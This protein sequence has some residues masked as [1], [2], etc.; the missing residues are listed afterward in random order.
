MCVRV[1]VCLC[2][3][4]CVEYVCHTHSTYIG[5]AKTIYIRCIY[6]NFGRK[7]TKYTVIYGV[8]IRFWPTL[9]IQRMYVCVYVCVRMCVLHTLTAIPVDF[10]FT[11]ACEL[12]S[13]T[14]TAT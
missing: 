14:D 13:G 1:C 3:L 10:K 12:H 7:I 5:L 2:V 8:Y 11:R 9:H 6:S 4:T